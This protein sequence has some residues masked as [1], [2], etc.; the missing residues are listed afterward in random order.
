MGAVRWV[1]VGWKGLSW[2][3]F[4]EAPER[5]WLRCSAA[6][7]CPPSA[8]TMSRRQFPL[9]L[10]HPRHGDGH[11]FLVSASGERVAFGYRVCGAPVY[12]DSLGLVVH[13][14]FRWC[15]DAYGN[16]RVGMG[17]AL[18]VRVVAVISSLPWLYGCEQTAI[19]HRYINF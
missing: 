17:V 16:Q 11:F 4:G 19:E 5:S 10:A 13:L 6:R 14:E 2:C 9:N 15:Q 18:G 8:R 7:C 12:L 1:G 3:R